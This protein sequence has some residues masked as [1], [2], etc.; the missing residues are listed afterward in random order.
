MRPSCA[1]KCKRSSYA[2][3]FMEA[4]LDYKKN[5][6]RKQEKGGIQ[7]YHDKLMEAEL[8]TSNDTHPEGRASRD[9]VR[10]RLMFV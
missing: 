5:M 7:K 9:T 1:K 6:K 2:K 4:E 8:A 10:Q 3:R